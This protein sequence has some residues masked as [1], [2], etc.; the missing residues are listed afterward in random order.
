MNSETKDTAPDIEEF[1]KSLPPHLTENFEKADRHLHKLY[2][3]SP[4]VATLMRLWIACGTSS[5]IQQEFEFTVMDLKRRGINPN[6]E[7][8]FD[9]D[10]L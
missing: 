9:E 6:A 5:L 10:C 1:V 4:G 2:G 8:E 7:G 3:A